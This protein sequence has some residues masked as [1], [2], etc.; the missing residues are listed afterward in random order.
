MIHLLFFIYFV[1]FFLF[2]HLVLGL[3]GE[4]RAQPDELE[5]KKM[6]NVFNQEIQVYKKEIQELKDMIKQLQQKK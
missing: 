5:V 4:D 2:L 1:F 6:Q 3:V